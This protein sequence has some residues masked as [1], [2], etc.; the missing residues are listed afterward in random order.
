[1]TW[2]NA[3]NTLRQWWYQTTRRGPSPMK[4]PDESSPLLTRTLDQPSWTPS[5]PTLECTLVVTQYFPTKVK[6]LDWEVDNSIVTLSIRPDIL[7]VF[8]TTSAS[9][10]SAKRHST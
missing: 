4:P 7:D 10:P 9:V 6:P 8:S 5:V 2:R 3:S 1:M